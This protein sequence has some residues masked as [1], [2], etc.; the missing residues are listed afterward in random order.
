MPRPRTIFVD[1]DAILAAILAS[2]RAIVAAIDEK[3]AKLTPDD[4][5]RWGR[6]QFGFCNREH[7]LREERRRACWVT[8][9]LPRLVGRVLTDSQRVITR[10]AI[11]QMESDGWVFLDPETRPTAIKLTPEGREKAAQLLEDSKC[12]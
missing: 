4:R 9:D 7:E 12:S 3:L 2:E 5:R 8:Y 1:Q 11:R 6:T 10:K